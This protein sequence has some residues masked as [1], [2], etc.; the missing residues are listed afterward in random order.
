M[1]NGEF[2][3]APRQVE[4]SVVIKRKQS[5]GLVAAVIFFA[6]ISIGLGVC[7]AI[8]MINKP[9]ENTASSDCDTSK[10][11]KQDEKEN[12]DEEKEEEKEE[13]KKPST[14]VS[15][16]GYVTGNC[17]TE[18]YLTSNGDVYLADKVSK[19]VENIDYQMNK[20]NAGGK[21]GSYSVAY[22]S[23]GTYA[24]VG[25]ESQTNRKIAIEGSK[26][27]VANILNA[28]PISYGQA[29][30]EGYILIG[31]DG[32]VNFVSTKISGSTY[33][34]KITKNISGY[35]DAVG[36][37][38]IDAGDDGSGAVII[39]KDGSQVQFTVKDEY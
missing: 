33:S 6:I 30:G 12:G 10:E 4:P 25:D 38:S 1:D 5:K 24:M 9:K 23:V 14:V 32:S 21:Y 3:A 2:A 20:N 37:V 31:A 18:L 28:Y 19:C 34:V 11:E 16:I 36:V 35:S 27:D 7:L 8:M 13:E 39:K 17:M 29:G 22:D 15:R 26:L